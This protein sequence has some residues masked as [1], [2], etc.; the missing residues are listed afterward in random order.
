MNRQYQH[1]SYNSEAIESKTSRLG[2]TG[3]NI[4]AME[5]DLDDTTKAL[6][7]DRQ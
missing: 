7:E 3:V 6:I 2:E 1:I 5:E 4:V